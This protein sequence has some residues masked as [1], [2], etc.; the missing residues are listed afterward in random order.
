[1]TTALAPTAPAPALAPV[2]VA[3]APPAAAL[4]RNDLV[5]TPDGFIAR[6][7]ALPMCGGEVCAYVQRLGGTPA[8][9]PVRVLRKVQP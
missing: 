7:K 3:V 1:M 5:H 9:F 4:Q 6:V 8:T 2:T